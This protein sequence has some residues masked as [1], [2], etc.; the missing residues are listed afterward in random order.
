MG[1]VAAALSTDL[2]APIQLDSEDV[3]F[4]TRRDALLGHLKTQRLEMAERAIFYN[5]TQQTSESI[6]E[7]FSR[8]KKLSE[9]CNFKRILMICYDID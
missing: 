8:L 2:L 6:A 9:N 3:A 1:P 4:E 7:F 5:A